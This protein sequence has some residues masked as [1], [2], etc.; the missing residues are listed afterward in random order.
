MHTLKAGILYFILVFG[1]GFLLGP[2]RVLWLVPRVGVRTAELIESPIMFVVIFLA[3]RWIVRR[4]TPIIT[5]GQ[6]LGIGV[7]ALFLLV[8]VEIVLTPILWGVS[9]VDYLKG[10][11][12][13][14]N[15]AFAIML[16][17]FALMPLLLARLSLD[18]RFTS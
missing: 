16:L 18:R 10:R 8:S 7:V 3:A 14:A 5:A 1:A 11:D 13:I 6:R 15:T 9:F 2:M 12:P 4:I 17:L